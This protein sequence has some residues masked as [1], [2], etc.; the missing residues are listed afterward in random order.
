MKVLLT[1]ATGFVG[2]AVARRLASAGHEIRALVR[3]GS[4]QRNLGGLP[5]EF[6]VGDLL[7]RIS[8]DRA[9]AGCHA[10]FHVA[11]DYRLWVP[12]PRE[13]YETNVTGRT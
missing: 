8:L 10:L 3:P 1:G 5:V 6:V 13:I 11:A 4:D 9:A 7:D 2:S 12:R